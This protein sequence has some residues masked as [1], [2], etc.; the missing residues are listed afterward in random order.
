MCYMPHLIEALATCDRLPKKQ[1]TSKSDPFF[2]LKSYT[3]PKMQCTFKIFQR[4]HHQ[5]EIHRRRSSGE[6]PQG[7]VSNGNTRLM[8]QAA[9]KTRC[10]KKEP[11]LLG[12]SNTSKKGMDLQNTITEETTQLEF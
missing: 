6:T 1:E 7:K 11:A 12:K 3:P 10:F 5:W 8:R 2:F 4:D 9:K